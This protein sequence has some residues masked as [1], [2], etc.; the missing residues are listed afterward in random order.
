MIRSRRRLVLIGA[1][2]VV[3]VVGALFAAAPSLYEV[4]DRGRDLVPFDAGVVYKLKLADTVTVYADS[5]S[6]YGVRP[7]ILSGAALVAMATATL[8]AFLLL[9]AAGERTKLVRFYGVAALGLGFLAADE[10]MAIHETIG[11]NLLFLADLPG[12]TRPDDVIFALYLIPA[13]AFVLYFRDVLLS[14]RRAT[15]LFAAAIG[16]FALAVIAD[17]L[18]LTTVEEPIEMLTAVCIVGGMVSLITEHLA[19]LVPPATSRSS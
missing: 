4:E 11:L 14:S 16:L 17:I 2:A 1:V 10:L 8:M 12:I 9:S 13:V 19:A 5:E 15:Q 18:G 6:R 3:V 7:D